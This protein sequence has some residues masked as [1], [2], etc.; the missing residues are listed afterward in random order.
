VGTGQGNVGDGQGSAGGG[1][2]SAGGNAGQT[3]IGVAL[4]NYIISILGDGNRPLIIHLDGARNAE[5]EY[6]HAARKATYDKNL[7]ALKD[8]LAT[9][10]RRA[11][12]NKRTCNTAI[13]KIESLLRQIFTFTDFERSMLRTSLTLGAFGNPNVRI[14]Q[15]NTEADICIAQRQPADGN[16]RIVVTGDSDL[17]GYDSVKRVLRSVPRTGMFAWYNKTDILAK[18]DLPTATHLVMLA[19]VSKNDYG[20]NIKGLGIVSNCKIIK[21][22]AAGPMDTMLKEYVRLATLKVGHPVDKSIFDASERVFFHVQDT[23][24]TGA[25]AQVRNVDFLTQV[26][27]YGRIL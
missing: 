27:T 4:V 18:L 3:H 14:C 7:A 24:L 2:S 22:I 5:K 9:M 16:E 1:Q 6:A 15:C 23:L 11:N 26:A 25:A 17:L 10:N 13:K 8:H 21:D 19:I 20:P 12:A